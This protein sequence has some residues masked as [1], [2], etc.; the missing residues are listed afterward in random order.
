MLEA[1]HSGRKAFT[2]IELVVSLAILILIFTIA[3]SG[4][5]SWMRLRTYYDQEMILQQNFRYALS[6]IS[7]DLM[8]ASKPEGSN[9]SL[10]LA[11]D[12][13]IHSGN[14]MGEELIFTYYDGIDTWDIRY[15]MKNTTNG[16]AVYRVKY[17]HGTSPTSIG[18]PVTENMKQLVKLYFARQGGK[19]VVMM[20]G[21]LN[22]FGKEQ[23]ISYT[24]LIYSRNSNEQSP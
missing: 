24:S 11:P 13:S 9:F 18:E 17:L 8:Q 23:T 19:V 10:I 21:N 6:R 16:N 3:F 14:A 4:I 2:L 7:S 12:D 20:V 1:N 5:S 15:R 22:Y